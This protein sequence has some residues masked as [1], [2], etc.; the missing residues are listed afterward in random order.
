MLCNRLDDQM[1][2][3]RDLEEE[4][5]VALKIEASR[6]QQVHNNYTNYNDLNSDNNNYS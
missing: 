4:F 1:R 3:Y 2:S 6:Y 5:R